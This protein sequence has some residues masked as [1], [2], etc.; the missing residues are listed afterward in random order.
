MGLAPYG[1]P[2]YV[3][4]IRDHLIDLRPD[5]SFRME[6]KY[7]NYLSGL[8]MTNRR[9]A[10]LFGG[11]PRAAGVGDHPAGDRP[12]GVD[13]GGHRGRS[14][15]RMARA[16]AR[17]D[18]RAQRV[19][20]R[21][22]RAQLRGQRAAAARG[23]VRETSGSNRRPATPAARSAPR[24]T[25]GTRSSTTPRGRRRARPA[26]RAP[27]SGR[28]SAP[29]RSRPGSTSSGYPYERSDRAA[30][31]RAGRR[32]IADGDVV[33]LLQGRMEFGPRALGHRSIIGD[34][35]SPAMQSIMNLKIKYR[36]SFRPFAPAVLDDQASKYFDIEPGIESPY[37]LL[38]ADVRPE[39]RVDDGARPRPRRRPARP[40]STRCARPSPRS[41]T[42]TTR[43][44]SRRWRRRR[45][46]SSTPSSRRSSSSR[47]ARW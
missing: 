11:P 8:T 23:P 33:G 5:G 45:A 30:R 40:G 47:A 17:V 36:E 19:P 39:L 3:D 20:G 27:T 21:R 46:P 38:V 29:T 4:R 28:A 2:I 31:A 7:F 18:R 16:A 6:M 32:A 10:E 44:A 37:M 12:R 42:S 41:P 14:C 43:R 9:F 22:R 35:R 26:C 13:P 15:S 1:E 34:P 24:S 25:G